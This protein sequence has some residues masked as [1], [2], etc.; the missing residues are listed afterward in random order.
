MEDGDGGDRVVAPGAMGSGVARRLREHGAEVLTP[1]ARP[2]FGDAGTGGDGGHGRDP[3]AGPAGGGHD[4]IDRA[5]FLGEDAAGAAVFEGISTT[6]DRIARD[7]ASA[8]REVGTLQAF[9]QP[10]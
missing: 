1:T 7:A 10:H 5:A 8:R 2:E 9:V 4:P 3:R 6:Y